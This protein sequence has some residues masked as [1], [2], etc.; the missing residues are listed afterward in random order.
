MEFYQVC[1]KVCNARRSGSLQIA[2]QQLGLTDRRLA[3]VP[4]SEH[5]AK[6]AGGVAFCS[7][8]DTLAEK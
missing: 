2:A 5:G 6:A 1:N 3:S 4:E 7:S 8:I